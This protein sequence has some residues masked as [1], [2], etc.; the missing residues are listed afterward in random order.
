MI[1][2]GKLIILTAKGQQE[3]EIAYFAK[4]LQIGRGVTILESQ[5]MNAQVLTQE[6]DAETADQMLREIGLEG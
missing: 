4:G 6:N 3:R 5:R 2:I 1:K